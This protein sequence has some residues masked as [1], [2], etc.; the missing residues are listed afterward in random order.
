ML[1]T[2]TPTEATRGRCKGSEERGRCKGSEEEIRRRNFG[3]GW[4]VGKIKEAA[5]WEKSDTRAKDQGSEAVW[6]FL[7]NKAGVGKRRGGD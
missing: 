6:G 5:A 7:S 1:N 2:T 4:T 3:K